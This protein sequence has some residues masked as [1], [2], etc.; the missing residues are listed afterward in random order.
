MSHHTSF[1]AKV[2]DNPLKTMNLQPEKLQNNFD[3]AEK[4][5]QLSIG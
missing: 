4:E 1:S 2:V 5:S 3:E